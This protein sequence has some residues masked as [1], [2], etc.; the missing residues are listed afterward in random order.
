[1]SGSVERKG[2]GT[3]HTSLPS[4]AVAGVT[5]WLGVWRSA[6]AVLPIMVL[7]VVAR[8]AECVHGVQTYRHGCQCAHQSHAACMFK[9]V[10]SLEVPL[11][12]CIFFA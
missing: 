8:N 6:V 9:S 10:M 1:M 12:T 5:H 7:S 3:A 11:V 4:Q 2:A